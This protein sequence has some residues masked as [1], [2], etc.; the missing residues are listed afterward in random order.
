[1]SR[2]LPF[3]IRNGTWYADYHHRGERVRYTLG[4]PASMPIRQVWQIF[5]RLE[6]ER[7]Q[8]LASPDSCDYRYGKQPDQ[9]ACELIDRFL[10]AK[11]ASRKPTI[12][13]AISTSLRFKVFQRCGFKCVYCGK[14]PPQSELHIDHIIPVSRGGTNATKN[15][16]AACAECNHGKRD[17]LINWRLNENL[18]L[19]EVST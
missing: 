1:M 10:E 13:K 6:A 17:R 11:R 16:V 2:N 14:A 12:R 8:R 19:K 3:I 7:R 5:E 15:L 4:M 9:T 18:F